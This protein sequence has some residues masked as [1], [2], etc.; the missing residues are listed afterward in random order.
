MYKDTQAGAQG[1][2]QET[3]PSPEADDAEVID[4]EFVDVDEAN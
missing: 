2:A 4:A 1:A 3:P